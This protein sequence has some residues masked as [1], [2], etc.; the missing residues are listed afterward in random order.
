MKRLVSVIIP[1]FNVRPYICEALDSVLEQTFKNLEILVVDDGSNDGS[2]RICDE[3]GRKDSR[4]TVIHQE[5]K[6]LSTA[7]N[8][9]LNRVTGE[10]IAFLD[11]DDAFHP[12]MI[13][14]MLEAMDKSKADIVVCGFHN[15]CSNGRMKEKHRFYS[16]RIQEEKIYTKRDA[17]SALLE[18]KITGH[19]WNKLYKAETWKDVRFPDGNVYEDVCTSYRVLSNAERVVTVHGC[20]VRHRIRPG[21]ITQTISSNSICDWARARAQIE[22]FVEENTPSLFNENQIRYVKEQSARRAVAMWVSISQ[23]DIQFSSKFRKEI[24]RK[25][26]NVD[27]SAWNLK[28]RTAYMVMR[29]CPELMPAIWPIYRV[30]RLLYAKFTG[31]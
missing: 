27:I 10:I 5:N 22:A 23:A 30:S 3:Y 24:L 17:L 15:Y 2:E 9:G 14:K 28:S 19:A 31:R 21:S 4:I 13:R 6:G 20:P 11:S 26:R 25:T 7:R 16:G 1:V 29:F 18:G 8:V 12:D